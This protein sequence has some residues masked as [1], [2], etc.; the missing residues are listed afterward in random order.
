MNDGV[1]F[2]ELNTISECSNDLRIKLDDASSYVT[3]KF[4]SSLLNPCTLIFTLPESYKLLVHEI[5]RFESRCSLTSKVLITEYDFSEELQI[6]NDRR[7]HY[8]SKTSSFLRLA[9][10]VNAS[11]YCG[12]FILRFQPVNANMTREKIVTTISDSAI[13]TSSTF[14]MSPF[15]SYSFSNVSLNQQNPLLLTGYGNE[16]MITNI[17][18]LDV[19]IT[20]YARSQ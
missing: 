2:Y 13:D 4:R 9:F 8:I 7:I 10:R 6:Y 16:V 3:F 14:R 18:D 15:Y 17:K 1:T 20:G 12:P 19:L 11:S 5:Y